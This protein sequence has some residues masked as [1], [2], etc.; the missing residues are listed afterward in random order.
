MNFR[1]YITLG[2]FHSVPYKMKL[3]LSNH[4]FISNF[5]D[6]NDYF[7]QPS[8]YTGMV[9]LLPLIDSNLNFMST[10]LAHVFST[11]I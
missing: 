2:L 7:F 8:P 4:K 6:F 10:L 1:S 9:Q 5:N 3:L 11:Y